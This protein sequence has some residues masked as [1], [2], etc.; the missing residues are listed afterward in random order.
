MNSIGSGIMQERPGSDTDRETMAMESLLLETPQCMSFEK[1]PSWEQRYDDAL[2]AYG[3][4][5]VR[6]VFKE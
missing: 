4:L 5:V 2:E 6:R 3:R 1:F